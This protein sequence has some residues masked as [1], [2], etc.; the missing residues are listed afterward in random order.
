MTATLLNYIVGEHK[1][2]IPILSLIAIIGDAKDF[3]QV[4]ALVAIKEKPKSSSAMVCATIFLSLGVD[5]WVSKFELSLHVQL[6][7]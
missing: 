1:Q 2:D 6:A 5:T 7:L 4:V 3:T